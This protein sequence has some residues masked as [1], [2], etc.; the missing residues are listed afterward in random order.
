M[1]RIKCDSLRNR[2]MSAE[3]AAALISPGSTLGLS[4]FTGSGYPKA[5]PLALAERIEAEH[6]AGNPF[7]I[8]SG[9]GLRPGLNSTA[10][11]LR[12]TASSFAC[13]IIPIPLRA[14]RSIVARWSISTCT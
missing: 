9:P 2:I 11:W 5:V 4:G 3:D 10:R 6:A 7:R 8:R 1:C 14:R 12:L 13:P